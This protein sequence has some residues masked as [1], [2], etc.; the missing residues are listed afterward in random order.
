MLERWLSVRP[1]AIGEGILFCTLKG[2]PL[3]PG[4]RRAMVARLARRAGVTRRVHLHG[5]R[6]AHAV[7][8]LREGATLPEVQAQLGHADLR[9]TSTYLR[10]VTPEDLAARA[11]A[12]VPWVEARE[13]VELR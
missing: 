8:S 11:R 3:D 10:H 2:T 5:L 4:Y 13:A 7:E 9:T 6:H 1:S 12:R